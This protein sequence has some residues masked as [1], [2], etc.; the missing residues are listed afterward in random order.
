MTKK[1]TKL[2][3]NGQEY[4]IREYQ[5]AGWQPWVNTLLYLPLESDVVDQSGKSPTRVFSTNWLS[6]T[7]VW[8]VP[9]VHIWTTWWA[10]LTTPYPLVSK[11]STLPIT[12]SVLIYVTSAQTSSRRLIMDTWAFNGNRIWSCIYEGTTNIRFA[13]DYDDTPYVNLYA[14]NYSVANS[15]IHVLATVTTTSSHLYIN[16]NL[17]DSWWW[18]PA[19]AWRWNHTYDNTQ[20][21]LCTRDVNKYTVA[22]NWNA[23]ELI[24]EQ[25]EW[26]VQEVASYYTWIKNKLGF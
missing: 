9:S 17:V 4:E 13:I 26:T 6:Y 3:L 25:T 2:M 16:W 20:W 1:I 8:W 15:W 24:I 19:P 5:Q 14:N 23:R 11:D 18:S 10:K 7:T 12:F 22:L 21:I